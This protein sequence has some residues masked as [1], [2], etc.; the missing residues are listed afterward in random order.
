MGSISKL[1]AAGALAGALVGAAIGVLRQGSAAR[2]AARMKDE[3]P[4]AAGKVVSLAGSAASLATGD[5]KTKLRSVGSLAQQGRELAHQ[6]REEPQSRGSR[7]GGDDM[8]ARPVHD[9][10]HAPTESYD[11]N[12]PQPSEAR[13]RGAGS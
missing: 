13:R 10:R 3:A 11:H 1:A 7:A 6:L 5:A 9:P 2:I 12:E 4:S 8:T